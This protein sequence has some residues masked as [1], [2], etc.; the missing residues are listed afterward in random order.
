MSYTRFGLMILTSTVIMFGLMYLNTYALDHVF[1][2]QTR[3]WMA[4]VMGAT[5][6]VIMLLFM[7]GMYRNRTANMAILGASVLVFAGALWLVRSQ[8]TVGDVAY[9]KAMIPHHSIAIM[10][11]E[12]ARIRDPRV[13]QLADSII[14]AQ[15]REIGEMKQLVAELEANPPASSAPVI[16][17]SR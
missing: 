17:P 16:P 7:L 14:D 3:T 5:M 9:M 1:Y 10:T 11:S 4:I 15:V 13:R 6:A 2:S 12:R 8:Q